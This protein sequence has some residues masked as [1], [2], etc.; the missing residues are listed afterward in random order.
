ME[1][2][3]IVY[4]VYHIDSNKSYI[5]Q[6]SKGLNR[7]VEHFKKFAN[8]KAE[9][10][11]RLLYRA[12]K[13][14]GADQFSYEVLEKCQTKEDMNKQECFW[15]DKFQSQNTDL[16]YNIRH[17]GAGGNTWG[18]LTPEAKEAAL[19][20]RSETL[21]NSPRS[22]ESRSKMSNWMKTMR[23]D[24]EKSKKNREI[25]SKRM[26]KLNKNKEM[27]KQ[28]RDKIRIT[29]VR[30][31]TSGIILLKKPDAYLTHNKKSNMWIVQISSKIL[32]I[33]IA[34][35]FV[36]KQSAVHYRNHSLSALGVD[37]RY[38]EQDVQMNLSQ[39]HLDDSNNKSAVGVPVP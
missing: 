22:L 15:I 31:F 2:E 25:H 39:E 29:Q 5:G 30:K 10:R 35:C 13:K 34:S 16:G 18:F 3:F 12:M 32:G 23:S 17:G 11:A 28:A 33:S 9:Y 6:C 37:L 38:L 8:E 4:R 36:D 1:H 14:H 20:K 26:T 7:V 27:M 21:K 19:K 24:P